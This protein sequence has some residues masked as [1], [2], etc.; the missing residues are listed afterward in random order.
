MDN[1]PV[2]PAVIVHR[3]VLEGER[4]LYSGFIGVQII[5]GAWEDD[6]AA[7]HR[8]RRHAAVL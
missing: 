6:N 8:A 4:R 5:V 1:S 2:A 7:H 3:H